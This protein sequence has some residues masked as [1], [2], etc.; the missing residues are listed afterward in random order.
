MVK[1]VSQIG[2]LYGLLEGAPDEPLS[3]RAGS[4]ANTA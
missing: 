4:V 2:L 3:R 1:S